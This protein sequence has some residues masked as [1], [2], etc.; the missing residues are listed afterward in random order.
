MAKLSINLVKS[1][2]LLKEKYLA[3]IDKKAEELRTKL[4]T[5]S[6]GQAMTYEE[7]YLEALD[8]SGSPKPFLEKEA[9]ALG[10]SV[11][12]VAESVRNA[13]ARWRIKGPEIEARRMKAKALIKATEAPADMHAITRD[14]FLGL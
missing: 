8:D 9:E 4:I 13:R 5:A 6:P 10:V 3:D 14:A 11:E 1:R 7:K 2:D 12:E